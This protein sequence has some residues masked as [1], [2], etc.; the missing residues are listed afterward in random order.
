MLPAIEMQGRVERDSNIVRFFSTGDQSNTNVHEFYVKIAQAVRD[1]QTEFLDS[2]LIESDR[3]RIM[4]KE[5]ET[6]E[7]YLKLNLVELE[8]KLIINQ[9]DTIKDYLDTISE[10]GDVK[11]LKQQLNDKLKNL[12]HI[13][14]DNAIELELKVQSEIK[15]RFIFLQSQELDKL[16]LKVFYLKYFAQHIL[17]LPLTAIPDAMLNLAFKYLI[18]IL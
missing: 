3:K 9:K 10:G 6:Y 14:I 15:E 2:I 7:C 11:S 1:S 18:I 17:P 5:R 12:I 4:Q 13:A 8:Q 16:S